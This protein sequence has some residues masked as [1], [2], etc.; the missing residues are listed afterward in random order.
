M[1]AAK[2]CQRDKSFDSR[3]AS[4][5]IQQCVGWG[6]RG[7]YTCQCQ[8]LTAATHRALSPPYV[9]FSCPFHPWLKVYLSRV[10][11]GFRWTG[12]FFLIRLLTRLSLSCH[13]FP[14]G[15][16]SQTGACFEP[17]NCYMA[18]AV[19]RLPSKINTDNSMKKEENVLWSHLDGVRGRNVSSSCSTWPQRALKQ[20]RSWCGRQSGAAAMARFPFTLNLKM[21]SQPRSLRGVMDTDGAA[22]VWSVRAEADRVWIQFLT[23]MSV[24]ILTHNDWFHWAQ[25]I[26]TKVFFFLYWI[27]ITKD[28]QTQSYR[29]PV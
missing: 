20:W 22:C 8:R 29:L 12:D 2:A 4:R 26:I 1:S 23:K 10:F 16:E 15:G 9:G 21:R 25:R 28:K 5:H 3:L 18:P 17:F 19:Q 27:V 7:T 14:A 24:F 13:V 11:F 6:S